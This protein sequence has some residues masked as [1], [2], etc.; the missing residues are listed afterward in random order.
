M[1]QANLSINRSRMA[2][3]SCVRIA[4][5]WAI[6]FAP[7]EHP[8]TGTHVEVTTTG[9]HVFAL[10]SRSV[11]FQVDKIVLVYIDDDFEPTGFGPPESVE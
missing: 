8:S 4:L 9:E 3:Q 11:D 7:I 1:I 6:A 10:G 2:A 5:L